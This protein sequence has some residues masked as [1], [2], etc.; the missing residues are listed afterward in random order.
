[1]AR[2]ASGA[3]AIEKEFVAGRAKASRQFRF[4]LSDAPFQFEELAAAIA[5]KMMVVLLSRNLVT[6]RIAGN[7]NGL[8]PAFLDQ[9]LNI[10]VY[11]RNSKRRM[12]ALRSFERFIWR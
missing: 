5:M 3:D 1:M 11:G 4:H 12:M 6:G 2:D 7:L 10:P 9:T 8:K